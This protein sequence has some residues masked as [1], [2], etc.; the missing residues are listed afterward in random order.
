MPLS[1]TEKEYPPGASRRGTLPSRAL[2]L[3]LGSELRRKN[4][5]GREATFPPFQ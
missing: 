1:N 2:K 3:Q 4:K 5:P